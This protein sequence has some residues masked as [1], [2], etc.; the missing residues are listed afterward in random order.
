VD[1]LN[2][3]CPER[4]L[5]HCLCKLLFSA[6]PENLF[7]HKISEGKGSKGMKKKYFYSSKVYGITPELHGAFSLL[8]CSP[9]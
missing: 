7:K 5:N 3:R 2:Q 1:L 9:G 8:H 6:S 4:N